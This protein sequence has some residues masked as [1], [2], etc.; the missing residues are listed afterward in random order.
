MGLGV[1]L[2]LLS[3]VAGVL[4]RWRRL[5][6]GVGAA[7][8]WLNLGS[9]PSS[10]LGAVPAWAWGAALTLGLVLY[11]LKAWRDAPFFPTPAGE[12]Q[13]LRALMPAT[14]RAALR[15]LDAGSGLGHGVVALQE[16]LPHADITGV[17]R[18]LPLWVASRWRLRRSCASGR[19]RLQR[20]DLWAQSWREFGMVYVFQ[21]PESM[22]RVWSKACRE[23]AQGAWLVSL[24]FSVPGVQPFRQLPTASGR[25]LWVYRVA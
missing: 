18:S 17:E 19:V 25:A 3:P 14:S 16:A 5:I 20:G 12:L 11:P 24:E 6:M 7:V 1:A 2:V 23:M 22:A 15:V 4:S 9:S 13:A 21:R 8:L 10:A